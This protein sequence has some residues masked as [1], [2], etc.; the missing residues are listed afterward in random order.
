M[1]EKG[2]TAGDSTG[3]FPNGDVKERGS[4]QDGS[5]ANKKEKNTLYLSY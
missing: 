2:R 4:H 5:R 1:G 3:Q